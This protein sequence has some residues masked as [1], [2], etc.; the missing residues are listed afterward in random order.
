MKIG[1][2]TPSGRPKQLK[3]DV[4]SY[5][6]SVEVRRCGKDIRRYFHEAIC[7]L[8]PVS[9]NDTLAKKL[10]FYKEDRGRGIVT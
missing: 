4:P 5:S 9:A 2:Q 6:V 8:A 10:G 3:E 7:Y 1:T